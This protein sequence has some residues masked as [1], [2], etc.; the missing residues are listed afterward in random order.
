LLSFKCNLYRYTQGY[1]KQAYG[2]EEFGVFYGGSGNLMACQIVGIIVIIAWTCGL[3][4]GAV[5][6]E[7]S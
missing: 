2:L 7:A 3:L 4:G 6:V 1:V 5:Q